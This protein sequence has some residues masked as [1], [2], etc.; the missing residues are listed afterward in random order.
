MG[1]AAHFIPC[2][3]HKGMAPPATAVE[4]G[5]WTEDDL[6]RAAAQA[7]GSFARVTGAQRERAEALARSI[8][9]TLDPQRFGVLANALVEAPEPESAVAELRELVGD[10]SVRQKF[11]RVVGRL[12]AVHQLTQADPDVPGWLRRDIEHFVRDAERLLDDDGPEKPRP[13]PDWV[14][15]APQTLPTGADPEGGL[16]P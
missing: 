12:R 13:V 3:M 9:E 11:A 5:S 2:P 14:D 10:S 7:D 16:E 15:D 1:R 4:A 6:R 8:R